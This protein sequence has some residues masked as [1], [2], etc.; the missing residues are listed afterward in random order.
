MRDTDE[1]FDYRCEPAAVLFGFTAAV[2]L[3]GYGSFGARGFQVFP[4]CIIAMLAYSAP[5]LRLKSRPGLDLLSHAFFIQSLPYLIC[6]YLIGGVWG[7]IDWALLAVNFLASLSGQLAQQVRDF[8]VDSRTDTNFATLV[9][10][11]VTGCCLQGATGLLGVIVIATFSAGILPLSLAPLALTFAPAMWSR[12]RGR[13]TRSGKVVLVCTTVALAYMV[14]LLAL[15]LGNHSPLPG[16][17]VDPPGG[18]PPARRPGADHPD[19]GPHHRD[20]R[21]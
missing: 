1:L 15:Q 10:L 14:W 12:L 2:L 13:G 17:Q 4:G 6:V 3:F 11:R 7:R 19:P 9:G 16:R 5:P 8:D 21:S 20:D 18:H